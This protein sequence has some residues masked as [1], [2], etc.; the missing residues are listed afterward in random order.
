MN[1]IIENRAQIYNKLPIEI[2]NKI[3]TIIQINSKIYLVNH[4][5]PLIQKKRIDFYI[6]DIIFKYWMV[7]KF[8]L[9]KQTDSHNRFFLNILEGDL[10][11][12]LNNQ[13]NVFSQILPEL[14]NFL[15]IIFDIEM[16]DYYDYKLNTRD[17]DKYFRVL[18]IFYE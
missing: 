8:N 10:L 1:S 6:R 7:F 11:Y 14:R 17:H 16:T 2:Q 5:C 9:L 13:N 15:Q 3:D 12:F 18:I 4:I